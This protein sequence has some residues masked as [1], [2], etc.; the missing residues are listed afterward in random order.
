MIPPKTECKTVQ[1][2]S[3]FAAQ[4]FIQTAMFV[5]DKI[6]ERRSPHKDE[7][8]KVTEPPK[9]K[10]TSKEASYDNNK[11]PAALADVTE[12]DTTSDSDKDKDTFFD[13]YEIVNSFAKEQIVCSLYQPAEDASF[14][15]DD[16]SGIF[17]LCKAADVV[18]VDWSLYGDKGEHALE[19]IVELIKQ[20]VSDV[21]EQLRLILVYTQEM[22]LVGVAEKIFKKVKVKPNI[23]DISKPLMEE[24]KLSFHTENCRITTL[25][26]SLR[27]RP[28]TDPQYVVKECDI[29]DVAVKEFAKLASG[30][31]HT[32]TLLGLSAIKQN[33]WKILS[34]FGSDLDPAFLTHRAMCPPEEDGSSHIIPLLVSEIKAV[35]EDA[36]P[37]PLVP[38]SVLKD[39]C[40]NVWVPGAHLERTF[41][42]KD[43]SALKEIA[44]DICIKGFKLARDDH[45][46]IP[47][48]E[49]GRKKVRDA[50]KFLLPTED[51][52][53]NRRFSHLMA[54]RTFYGKEQRTLKLGSIIVQDKACGQ[55]LLCVQPVCDSVRL[56]DETVFMFVKMCR[57]SKR[58]GGAV[59]HV[60]LEDQGQ[61]KDKVIELV[62]RLKSYCCFV[63]TFCPDSASQE[64]V[65]K[66]KAGR[67][68]FKD[69]EGGSY[70][71]VDQLRTS[72]AQRAVERF[73]RDLSRVG[74]TESEWIRRLEV[75]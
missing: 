57:D 53:V 15:S 23:D 34:R 69:S 52:D 60:V 65:V 1:E 55:Y 46:S 14:S 44:K 13:S 11:E 42:E 16:K 10:N 61:D 29:A 24:N 66:K 56:K 63:A 75:N 6:Y 64:V 35:L 68:H 22:D 28:D 51:S 54:S 40:Q 9:R 7:T 62:Y 37:S 59:S 45:E 58:F 4:S 33:S 49:G 2:Y 12:E 27:V 48:V 67:F 31:L 39:W 30:V 70:F 50:A 26:K 43:D 21:P 71:W 20:V 41:G 17:A 38:E 74:L 73:A 32:A 36:M 47:N 19:L 5:D 3:Q 72:H 18:I 8:K 25:G